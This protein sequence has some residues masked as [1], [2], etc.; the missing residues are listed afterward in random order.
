MFLARSS[1]ILVG[2]PQKLGTGLPENG[3]VGVEIN[4][5]FSNQSPWNLSYELILKFNWLSHQIGWIASKLGI[6]LVENGKVG[7]EINL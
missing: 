4:L 5:C 7:V 3:E 6:G 2:L 1:T